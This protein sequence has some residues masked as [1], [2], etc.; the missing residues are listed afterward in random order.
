MAKRHGEK[1]AKKG[2]NK[3]NDMK[4]RKE[5]KN[6]LILCRVSSIKQAQQGESIEV[7]ER[8]C[9][10]IAERNNL[11]VLKVFKE[12]FSGRKEDRPVI[13]EI[14]SYVKHSRKKVSVLI[15]RSID[16]FSRGGTRGYETLLERLLNKGVQLIDSNGIIQ[17]TK[18]TLEHLDLEYDWS[19]TRPSEI[20]ELIM[21]QQGKNEVNQILTRMIGAEVDLVR[22]GFKV[23]PPND[24][25][26][27]K[28]K[29]IDGKKRVIQV[30]DPERKDYYIKMFEM[31][32]THSDKDV[33]DHINAMG[34]RSKIHNIWSKEKDRIIGH[35]KG[36]KLT[37]KQLQKIRQRTIYAGVNT[38]KWLTKPIRTKYDGLIS[39]KTFNE[40]NKGK[41]FIEEKENGDI[42]VHRDYNI[43]MLKRMKD[44]PLFPHKSVVLCPVCG[45]PL[46][47]SASKGKS[48]KGFP[49][50]HCSRGHKRFGVNKLE[51]DKQLTKYVS[52]LKYENPDFLRS[53]EAVL[54]NKYR[55]KE[56]EF[57]EISVK[58]GKTVI[59]LETEKDQLL[60]AY[61]SATTEFV[62]KE[63]EKKINRIH[64]EIE[65]VRS[66]RNDLEI[67]END[68]HSF[69]RYTKQLMEHPVEMLVEQQDTNALKALFGLVFDELPTYDQI[70]KGTPKLSLVYKLKDEHENDERLSVTSRGIEPRL[71]P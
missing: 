19:I 11:T 70:V 29:F 59:E 4:E 57:G 7:Q 51:F 17:P 60:R 12:Q 15:F 9:R 13:E 65:E 68:I 14:F 23:R 18:N 26:L 55:E 66:Q 67:Q 5:T 54:M 58:K 45:K 62:R 64:D 56:R 46:L 8:I 69:V 6:C 34:Y 32:I 37:V 27:N 50:Y 48:G 43:H 25:F 52:R 30:P 71:Q 63:L 47:G 24:G 53:L 49:A 38:E 22:E 16:R 31:S 10:N 61:T 42:I 35:T 36:V 33:V 41:V 39:I 44:N 40:A 20:T 3:N 2:D 28:K 1:E 21:A